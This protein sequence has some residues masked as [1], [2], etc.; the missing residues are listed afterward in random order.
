MGRVIAISNQKG[1]VGKT[2]TAV[3]LS[4]SLGTL[5]KKVLLIDFDPQGNATTGVG[6][7]KY[8]VDFTSYDLVLGE[9]YLEQAIVK[10]DFANL[11]IVPSN[12]DL[13]GAEIDLINV[14]NRES[15]LKSYVDNSKFLYDFIIIDCPPSLS[16]LTVNALTAADTI[17]VPVQCEY[18]SLEG[19]S[20]LFHTVDIIQKRLNS[21][22]KIEGVVFTMFD[23]RTNLS[24]QVVENVKKTLSQSV[25]SSVIPRNIR[26]SE[27][28]SH[29]LP[30]TA[31]DP[32]SKGGIAYLE[33]ARKVI[34]GGI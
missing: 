14:D 16:T 17:L 11:S 3:N 18:Y 26:L 13:S 28:P 31:Y 29:R 27:A 22:L 10:T 4:A 32:T 9:C 6:V 5:N 1:G 33:L 19:L 34:K 2:T 12:I 20:S 25:Y 7:D 21:K 30:I 24:L 8:N 15:I 23:K